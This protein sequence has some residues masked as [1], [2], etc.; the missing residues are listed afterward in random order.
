MAPT[1]SGVRAMTVSAQL[2][3]FGSGTVVVGIVISRRARSRYRTSSQWSKSSSSI[4]DEKV[5]YPRSSLS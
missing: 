4:S 1:G 5:H 3:F 2:R